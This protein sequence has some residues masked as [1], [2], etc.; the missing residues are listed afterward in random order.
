MTADT[1]DLQRLA[2][3]FE[4]HAEAAVPEMRAIVARGALQV[5]SLWRTNAAAS[6]G[7]H[8]GRQYPRTISYDMRSIPGGAM[9][10]IGPDKDKPQGPL[11]NLLEFGTS[12]QAGHNDGGRALAVEEPLFTAQ[13]EALADRAA[14]L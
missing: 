1:R 5:K 12:K 11:G 7:K 2:R 6:G 3:I 8:A 10:E 4:D 13:V 9:A 14:R